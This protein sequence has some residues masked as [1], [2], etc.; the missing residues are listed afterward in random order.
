MFGCYVF[1][2]NGFL[3]DY[4]NNEGSKG[5]FGVEGLISLESINR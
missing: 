2:W 3:A 5:F 1:N 4:L